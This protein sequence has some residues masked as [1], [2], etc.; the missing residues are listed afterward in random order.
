MADSK[1]RGGAAPGTPG[2]AHKRVTFDATA[3]EHRALRLTAVEEGT[4]MADILR[5]L[6]AL[7]REDRSLQ[8]KVRRRLDS[9]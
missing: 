7:Y 5:A 8:A 9:S 2:S 6:V 3:D 4:T 1:K